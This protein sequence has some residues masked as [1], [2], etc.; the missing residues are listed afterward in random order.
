MLLGIAEAGFFPGMVLYLTY[1]I[2]ARERART[3]AWFMMAAPIAVIVGGPLSEALLT[4]DGRLG[5]AGWQWLF[6]IEGLP[7]VV[8]GVLALRVLTDRP[9]HADWLPADDREWLTATMAAEQAR[10]QSAGYA[11]IGASI[12]SARVWILSGVLFMHTLVQYGIFLWLP[13]MLQDVSGARGFALSAITAIPFAAALVAMVLVGRHSDRTGERKYHVAAC[14]ADLRGRPAA[15]GRRRRGTCGCWCSASRSRRWPSGRWSGVFW[16]LPPMFLGGTAAAAGLGL[17]NATGNLGGFFGPT[18][19]GWLRESTGGYAGGLLVLAA[20]LIVEVGLVLGLRVPEERDRIGSGFRFKVQGFKVQGSGSGFRRGRDVRAISVGCGGAAGHSARGTAHDDGVDVGFVSV[21]PVRDAAA[22][23][24]ADRL[25]EIAARVGA[26]GAHG[27][28]TSIDMDW[29][30]ATRAAEGVARPVPRDSDVPA[31]RGSRRCSST[32]SRSPRRPA[33]PA[34]ARCA[35]WGDATRCSTRSR[36]GSRRSAAS[37]SR[38]AAA[39]PILERHRLPLG[40]ENHKDFRVD[41]QVALL[42]AVQQRV[43]RRVAGHRQQPD[44]PRR[45]RSRRSRS[46]RR[47]RST[48]TSRTWPPRKQPT[49]SASPRCRSARAC[50]TSRGSPAIIR[51]AR[52]DV[53][54]SLEMI[55]RDPLEVPCLTGEVLVDVRRCERG[56]AGADAD[57]H[58][59]QRAARAAAADHRPERRRNGSSLEMELVDRSIVFVRHRSSASSSDSRAC[60]FTEPALQPRVWILRTE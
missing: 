45:S 47:T 1:W 3:G 4:L 57:P 32:R 43:P 20:A 36:A 53:H 29:A 26:G 48:S 31:A 11:T 17:I 28:M 5:L 40:L 24:A 56:G 42:R 41:Q 19:M 12:T 6:M 30:R 50:S 21:D 52:P 58:P 13:K 44:R 37:T 51:A 49:G 7:A 59:G 14:A 10:R 23:A 16:A 25:L 33:R 39:V 34:C 46:W 2:P 27:G 9:E 15:G 55:T 22:A 35:C 60:W 54:F 8:L 18:V 38:F